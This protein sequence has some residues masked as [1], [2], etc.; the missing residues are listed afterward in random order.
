MARVRPSLFA[1]HL[2]A[3]ARRVPCEDR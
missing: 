2:I 1:G 3:V